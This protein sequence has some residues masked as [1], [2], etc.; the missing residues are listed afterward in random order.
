MTRSKTNQATTETRI[1]TSKRTRDRSLVAIALLLSGV[2]CTTGCAANRASQGFVFNGNVEDVVVD[3][4]AGDVI[5]TGTDNGRTTV[6]LD[7]ACRG[8]APE[9]DVTYDE[10]RVVVSGRAGWRGEEACDGTVRI[11]APERASLNVSVSR[12]DV[13]VQGIEGEVAIETFAGDIECEAA[14][15]QVEITTDPTEIAAAAPSVIFQ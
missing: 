14:T 11:A 3:L 10:G 15:H 5:V 7:L 4:E 6:D 2:V 9:Y 8:G 12:G 13:A 1:N